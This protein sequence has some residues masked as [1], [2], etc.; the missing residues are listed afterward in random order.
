MLSTFSEMFWSD[1]YTGS[2]MKANMDG[3]IRRT[4]V[5]NLQQPEG[6]TIDIKD[7]RSVALCFV[8]YKSC[9]GGF[10]MHVHS[11][12]VSQLSIWG[13]FTIDI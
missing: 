4:L 8:V 5:D 10:T 13:G 2:V 12:Q 7:K 1:A 11:D 9:G 6:V 3:S